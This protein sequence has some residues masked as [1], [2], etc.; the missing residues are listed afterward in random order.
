MKLLYLRLFFFYLIAAIPVVTGY[1]CGLIAGLI[2]H[3]V[4]L[5]W[6]AIVEGY[7]VG[8]QI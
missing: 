5:V 6:A 1:V 4:R 7:T 3:L 8:R 2:N